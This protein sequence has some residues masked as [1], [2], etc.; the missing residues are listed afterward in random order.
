MVYSLHY[1]LLR[2]NTSH[3]LVG[4]KSAVSS[5]VARV[6]NFHQPQNGPYLIISRIS[7]C[8]YKFQQVYD[9][10]T[11]AVHFYH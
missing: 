11:M 8:T 4:D 10:K 1:S 5:T 6:K 9:H 3:T 7:D 2:N